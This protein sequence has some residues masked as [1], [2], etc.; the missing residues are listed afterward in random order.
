MV[1]DE[2]KLEFFSKAVSLFVLSVYLSSQFYVTLTGQLSS[3]N[4]DVRA[5]AHLARSSCLL[6]LGGSNARNALSASQLATDNCP[7][8]NLAVSEELGSFEVY[9]AWL[10]PHARAEIVVYSTLLMLS[11]S[12]AESDGLPSVLDHVTPL[13]SRL[14]QMFVGQ[15]DESVKNFTSSGD[16]VHYVCHSSIRD[17]YPDLLGFERQTPSVVA[18][19]TRRV[20]LI[21]QVTGASKVVLHTPR[22]YI[23]DEL[24]LDSKSKFRTVLDERLAAIRK[25][26]IEVLDTPVVHSDKDLFCDSVHANSKGRDLFT[27]QLKQALSRL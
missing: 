14:K 24:G 7:A 12:P 9:M 21:R 17:Q 3:L 16:Q 18:E 1:T 10:G 15:T 8:L 27:A 6:L 19:L 23:S 13:A 5:K 11:S 26:G 25:A 4:L 22:M 20:A 2:S